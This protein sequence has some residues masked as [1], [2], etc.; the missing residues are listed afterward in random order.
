M[1][2][3]DACTAVGGHIYTWN[4]RDWSSLPIPRPAD[5]A[6]TTLNSVSCVSPDSCVAVGTYAN[7]AGRNLPL[8]ES[9]GIGTTEER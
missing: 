4:G 9:L 2:L 8:V 7:R 3:A 5:A 6:A 1:C